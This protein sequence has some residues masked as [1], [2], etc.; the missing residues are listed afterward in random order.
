MCLLV[1]PLFCPLLLNKVGAYILKGVSCRKL[2]GTCSLLARTQDS[3]RF[4]KEALPTTIKVA[5]GEALALMI[6]FLDL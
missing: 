4:F 5:R 6:W 3:S 1:F 2:L